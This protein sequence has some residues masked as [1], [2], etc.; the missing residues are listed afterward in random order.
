MCAVS[1]LSDEERERAIAERREA[2]RVVR[3]EQ[4]VTRVSEFRAWITADAEV[5]RQRNQGDDVSRPP[6]PEVPSDHDYVL[7][8][9]SEE[10]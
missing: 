8:R 9:E 4:A 1:T 7:V 2:R 3:L 10:G 5:T 6:M